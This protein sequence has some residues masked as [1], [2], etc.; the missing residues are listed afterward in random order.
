MSDTTGWF[1]LAQRIQRYKVS[2]ALQAR[3]GAASGVSNWLRAPSLRPRA[4]AG[5]LHQTFASAIAT[6]GAHA[7]VTRSANVPASA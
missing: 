6:V 4:A 5:D 1:A 7:G 3:R 2:A